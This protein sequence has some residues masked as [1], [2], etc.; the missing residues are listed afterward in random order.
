M[1]E[2]EVWFSVIFNINILNENV[3]IMRVKFGIDLH[4]H[5]QKGASFSNAKF[6]SH[7]FFFLVYRVLKVSWYESIVPS[8]CGIYSHF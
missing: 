2:Y 7:F 4:G 1:Y 5:Y 3:Y 8:E 6:E